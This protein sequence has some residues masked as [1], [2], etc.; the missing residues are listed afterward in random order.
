MPMV[1]AIFNVKMKH[2][3]VRT[4]CRNLSDAHSATNKMHFVHIWKWRNQ[5]FCRFAA[6]HKNF[7]CT[8]MDF[9]NDVACTSGKRMSKKIY[10]DLSTH[11]YIKRCKA[12]HIRILSVHEPT[13]YYWY[14]FVVVAAATVVF[15]RCDISLYSLKQSIPFALVGFSFAC[16]CLMQNAVC[17]CFVFISFRSFYFCVWFRI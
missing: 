14:V 1:N 5:S 11:T 6:S 4:K 2:S 9:C 3:V 17:K 10:A 13:Y 7:N 8:Q 16:I 12:L 15:V